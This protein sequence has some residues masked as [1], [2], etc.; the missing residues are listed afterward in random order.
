VPVNGRELIRMDDLSGQATDRL[1]FALEFL[2]TGSL[3]R[4]ACD[5]AMRQARISLSLAW[6]LLLIKRRGGYLRQRVLAALVGADPASMGRSVD[7]LAA[8]G[9]VERADDPTDRRAWRVTLTPAGQD[10]S[11]RLEGILVALHEELLADAG[12]DEI[13]ALMRVSA[14]V[15]KRL[16]EGR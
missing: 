11:T 2:S 12:E 14:R 10:V 9:W 13:R 15:R 3:H 6:P 7:R 16:C 5:R 4:Q 8:M 1:S